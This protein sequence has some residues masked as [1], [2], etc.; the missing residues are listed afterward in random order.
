MLLILIVFFQLRSYNTCCKAVVRNLFC[1]QAGLPNIK[2]LVVQ[3]I[4][5]YN[6]TLKNCKI[7]WFMLYILKD[8]CCTRTGRISKCFWLII[9]SCLYFKDFNWKG[10]KL[11]VWYS[12]VPA[13]VQY[14]SYW[15]FF[16]FLW[17]FM[18]NVTLKKHSVMLLASSKREL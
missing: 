11:F 12:G 14:V 2:C 1:P 4:N 18:F 13:T 5:F 7:E 16:F 8:Y 15:S 6:F 17:Y 9:T 10:T 3:S